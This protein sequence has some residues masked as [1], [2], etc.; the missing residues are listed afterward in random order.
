MSP[1]SP[2]SPSELARLERKLRQRTRTIREALEALTLLGSGTLTTR[3]KVCGQKS[4]RCA[5]DPAARHG[6]YHEWTRRVE[7]RYRH[8]VVS[9]RQAELLQR[10]IANYREAQR[11]LRLW[12][13]ETAQLILE[14]EDLKR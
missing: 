14:S 9:P 7:G 4:C 5:L 2:I 13:A 8:S 6:P 11:L 10:A 1:S 3:T 12:E